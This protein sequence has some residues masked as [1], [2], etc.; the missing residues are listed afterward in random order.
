MAV[1]FLLGPGMW[2]SSKHPKVSPTPMQVRR[3]IAHLLEKDGHKVILMEDDPDRAG[4][5]LIQKFD[6][7]LRHSSTDVVIYWPAKAKMQTTYD[8]LILLCDRKEYL[9]HNEIPIWIVHHV[10][11]AEIRKDEFMIHEAGNRS[12]Y[13]TAVAKLGV[14]PLEWDDDSELFEKI[15]LLSKEIDL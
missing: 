1:V 14:N 4:E 11:V 6:R 5:D 7:L 8:E 10:S 15:K 2:D 9:D 3:Q 13:L 12:R